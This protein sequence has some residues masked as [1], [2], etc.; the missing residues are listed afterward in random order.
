MENTLFLDFRSMHCEEQLLSFHVYR[1]GGFLGDDKIIKAQD[2][3]T[4][5]YYLKGSRG[6]TQWQFTLH[7]DGPSGALICRV[8]SAYTGPPMICGLFPGPML[9]NITSERR[10]IHMERRRGTPEGTQ[11]FRGPDNREYH[12]RTRMHLWRNEMQCLDTEGEIMATYR[13]TAMA[14]SKDGELHI[15]PSGRFMTD[16]L[17]ATS[18]A[19]RTPDH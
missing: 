4:D 18:L 16:L 9:V 15:Y 7:A 8:S 5:M 14:I 12:W 6:D 2:K 10:P 11:W 17:V 1:V 19:I 13:A 3:I